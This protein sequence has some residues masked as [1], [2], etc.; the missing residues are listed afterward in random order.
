M[1]HASYVSIAFLV[2]VLGLTG[3]SARQAG[4]PLPPSG[5]RTTIRVENQNFL[6]MTVYVFRGSQRVRLGTVSGVSSRVFTIPQ[7]LVFGATPLRFQADPVGS[8]STAMSHEISV[9]PGD[10]V[11]MTIPNR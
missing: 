9:R 4:G 1:R 5:S 10:Q 3:C 8:R 6:D 11:T 7:N 2:L